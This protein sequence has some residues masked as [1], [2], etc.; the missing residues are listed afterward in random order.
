M[1]IKLKKTSKTRVMAKPGDRRSFGCNDT[2]HVAHALD[3]VLRDSH[4]QTNPIEEQLRQCPE[5]FKAGELLERALN[6]L[7]YHHDEVLQAERWLPPAG[8]VMP[9]IV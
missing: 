8:A 9:P 7:K 4:S 6:S 2:E 3:L 5:A 1:T